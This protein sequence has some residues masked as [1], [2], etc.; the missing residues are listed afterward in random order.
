MKIRRCFAG[1]EPGDTCTGTVQYYNLN[2]RS[3]LDRGI[4]RL[5]DTET[6]YVFVRL[7]KKET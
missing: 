4:V 1:L 6:D 5:N 3:L 2:T 7:P